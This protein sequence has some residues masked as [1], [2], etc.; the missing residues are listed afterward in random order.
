M[1]NKS[2][3]DKSS[4][5]NQLDDLRIMLALLDYM[6]LEGKTL[7]EENSA[8]R[9]NKIFSLDEKTKKHNL[10]NFVKSYNIYRLKKAI[11]NHSKKLHKVAAI[12]LFSISIISV[13]VLNA[14]AIKFKLFNFIFDVHDKYTSI[15]LEPAED[16]EMGYI[17]VS[18]DDIYIPT[19][20]PEGYE[21]SGFTNNDQQKVLQYSNSADSI[22]I[23]QQFSS[24]SSLNIDTE[25]ADHI[26]NVFIN[27]SEGILVE[28]E[29]NITISWNYANRLFLMEFINCELSYEE[30]LDIAESVSL[31]NKNTD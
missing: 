7:I 24:D 16:M 20:L 25:N 1:N 19:L 22:I 5:I 26:L 12:L 15:K 27:A 31:I 10:N 13:S 3:F 11:N 21:L 6:E 14:D 28:K 2:N 23:L 8:L 29:N 18:L 30:A 4:I 17:K 9:E